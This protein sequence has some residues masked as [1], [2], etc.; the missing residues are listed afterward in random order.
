MLTLSW[1]AYF[2]IL[3]VGAGALAT[4]LLIL[5]RKHG[6]VLF[7]PEVDTEFHRM[8]EIAHIVHHQHLAHQWAQEITRDHHTT[9]VCQPSIKLDTTITTPTPAH[10][11]DYHAHCIKRQGRIFTPINF[12]ICNLS[13]SNI[14]STTNYMIPPAPTYPAPY[15]LHPNSPTLGTNPEIF[16]HSLTPP[17]SPTK[18]SPTHSYPP[19]LRSKPSCSMITSEATV[20]LQVT[21]L[22]LQFSFNWLG[23]VRFLSEEDSDGTQLALGTE[24]QKADRIKLTVTRSH[25]SQWI[26]GVA[27]RSW[28]IYGCGW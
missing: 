25:G 15:P 6:M 13:H 26:K 4:A 22:K 9:P 11:S 28:V 14:L 16:I 27:P 1:W 5:F 2:L 3:S 12:N 10:T 24:S 21:L 23:T 17:T 8:A 18:S 19:G 20:M 7:S